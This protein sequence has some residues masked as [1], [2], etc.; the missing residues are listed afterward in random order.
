MTERVTGAGLPPRALEGRGVAPHV[1][2]AARLIAPHSDALNLRGF[3]LAGGTALAWYL[4]HRIS[5][6]LDFFTYT[7]GAFDSEGQAV[8]A[9]ILE[10]LAIPET[11]GTAANSDGEKDSLRMARQKRSGKSGSPISAL[12]LSQSR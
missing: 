6:D 2:A 3:R 5:D 9:A 7:A 8:I 1:T 4:G 12:T 10:P 11:I